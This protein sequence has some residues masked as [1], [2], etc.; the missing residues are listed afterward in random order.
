V[1]EY[2]E[3]CKPNYM[4]SYNTLHWLRVVLQGAAR[5][6][7][8]GLAYITAA[9]PLPGSSFSADGQVGC[10]RWLDTAGPEAF[11]PAATLAVCAALTAHLDG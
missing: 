2:G 3:G 5:L 11:T 6:K 1:L 8:Y 4:C 7:M 9:S 10:S